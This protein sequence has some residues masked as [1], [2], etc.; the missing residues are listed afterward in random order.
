MLGHNLDMRP[1]PE[2]ELWDQSEPGGNRGR[3]QEEQCFIKT[4]LERSFYKNIKELHF[5][6]NLIL[7]VD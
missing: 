1:E 4:G 5:L 2:P 6:Q 3:R 7:L